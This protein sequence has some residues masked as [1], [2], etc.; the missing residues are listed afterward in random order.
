MTFLDLILL[1][2]F[3]LNWPPLQDI[4]AATGIASLFELTPAGKL[5]S[6]E[7]KAPERCRDYD[8]L[9]VF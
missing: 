5:T 1:T 7:L 4:L 3:E 6:D 9:Q 8:Y 2:F